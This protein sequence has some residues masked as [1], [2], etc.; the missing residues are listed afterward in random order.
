MVSGQ[1]H[2]KWDID[3]W[4][5]NDRQVIYITCKIGRGPALI[6][7]EESPLCTYYVFQVAANNFH[8]GGGGGL[9][10]GRGQK[11]GR[12]RLVIHFLFYQ[13]VLYQIDHW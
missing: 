5:F 7:I 11:F 6:I 2:S 8:A 13:L 1:L 3:K 12:L 4:K 9:R 10:A